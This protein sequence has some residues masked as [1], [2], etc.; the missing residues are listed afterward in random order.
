[1]LPLKTLLNDSLQ[2]YKRN[3]G[4]IFTLCMPFLLAGA[5]MNYIIM[6]S[7]A[8]GEFSTNKFFVSMAVEMALYPMYAGSLILM[9]AAQAANRLP[10]NKELIAS[11][12]AIYPQ[13]LLLGV[14]WR[15]LAMAGFFF[16]ILPGIWV[17]V[18]MAFAEFFLVVERF[19]PHGAIVRSF[20]T[21]RPHFF[22]IL[23]AL[24]LIALPVFMLTVLTGSTL[25]NLN[26]PAFIQIGA[27]ALIAFLALILHVVMF[28]IFMEARQ[29]WRT[30]A[31]L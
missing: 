20:Q 5:V 10:T 17:S 14:V 9:M 21:T 25:Y 23:S 13:L 2:F 18:R 6:G 7:G 24:A 12:L 27:E 30:E 1:M 15:T 29:N 19:D 26:A 22:L 16:L 4:Q 31:A 11:A 28:R 3:L 8:S